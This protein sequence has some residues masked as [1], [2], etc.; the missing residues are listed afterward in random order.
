MSSLVPDFDVQRVLVTPWTSDATM[1]GWIV[2]MG[3][4]VATTCGWVGQYLLLRRMALMG[5]ALS[6]SILPGLAGAFL[7]ASF[8]N[9]GT[10]DGAGNARGA[11]VMYLGA[12][13]AALVTTLLIHW[14]H[15]ASRVKQD[16][17]IGIVFSG[18]FALGV[19][20]ITVFADQVDLDADCVLY[21]EI[22]TVGFTDYF[23]LS[24]RDVAP[25]PVARMAIVALLTFAWIQ[26]FYK[27][28]LVSSFDPGLAS[29][30]GIRANW[31]HGVLMLWLSVVIVSAFES[32]G[33]ILVV[34]MLI[35]PGATASLLS[36]S[37]P[38]IFSL[39][40][41]H[42]AI[43]SL[44]GL[45]LALWL[46]CSIAGAMVVTG[47]GL[48]VLAWLSHVIRVRRARHASLPQDAPP[49]TLA[50]PS[51]TPNPP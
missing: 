25:L 2:L 14:L 17:A 43:S 4:L 33:A 30:L 39:I 29:S 1:N 16:A 22:G 10:A 27:E 31:V 24:G 37:L 3:F 23:Q 26:L 42:A 13:A 51:V 46:D 20:L 8:L 28:L 48:F 11:T 19:I 32:V 6:H 49:G 12:L 21:G 9:P 41:L 44:F 34:A 5:D 36:T 38:R 7:I 40:V 35:V 47:C 50:S 18:L 15:T 45:H